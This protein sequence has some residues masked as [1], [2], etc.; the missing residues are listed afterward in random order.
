MY[1]DTLYYTGPGL[2]VRSSLGPSLLSSTGIGNLRRIS[3]LRFWI[4]EDSTQAESE[5]Q[6]VEFSCTS[7]V[8]RKF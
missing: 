8:T 5:I 6:G 3:V 4:S 7:G 1:Y 2:G